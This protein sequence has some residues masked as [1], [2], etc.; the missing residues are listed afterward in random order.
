MPPD[1]LIQ[2]PEGRQE[3]ERKIQ[4][5]SAQ[6]NEGQGSTVGCLWEGPIPKPPSWGN[7]ER[8]GLPAGVRGHTIGSCCPFP[9]SLLSSLLPPSLP[10]S[11]PP[12]FPS[13]PRCLSWYLSHTCLADHP[14]YRRILYLS[15]LAS[16]GPGWLHVLLAEATAYQVKQNSQ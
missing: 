7:I 3:E 6:L 12:S 9:P 8:R 4:V 15:I 5:I 14:G 11:L 13:F 10:H 16:L 1:E 2:I